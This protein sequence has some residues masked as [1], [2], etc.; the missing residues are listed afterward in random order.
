MTLRDY[1]SQINGFATFSKKSMIHV[2]AYYLEKYKGD[3]EFDT[4]KIR[5]LFREISVKPP[6]NI[7]HIL[8]TLSSGRNSPLI[9]TKKQRTNK[10]YGLSLSGR[11]E[12]KTKI[13]VS[14]TKKLSTNLLQNA[15]AKVSDENRRKFLAETIA[16][17]DAGAKRASIIM[18]WIA[19]IDHFYDYILATD[20]NRL[21]FNTALTNANKKIKINKK[22]DFGE[23]KE[24]DFIE[25]C[26]TAKIITNDVRKILDEKLGIRNTCAHPSSVEIHETKVVN[27][28]EDLLDNVILKY[29][30]P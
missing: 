17:L 19:M 8:K 25:I 26:R 2:F 23:L 27:F 16:C 28:I 5:A 9:Y 29:S 1:V 14:D 6:T 15:V 4:R 30:I 24:K 18:M 10:F 13:P 3:L 20:E 7:P 21:S 22:D 11:D 12:I